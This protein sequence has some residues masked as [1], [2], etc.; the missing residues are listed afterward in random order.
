[1]RDTQEGKGRFDL[2]PWY[3]LERLAQ[4]Y[5]NGARKYAPNNWRKGIPLSRYMDSA[6][7]HLSKF[8]QGYREEDHLVA[9]IWNLFGYVWTEKQINI[10]KLPKE[11]N[12]I[13][14]HFDI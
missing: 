9:C 3:V 12:D 10:G 4:H 2:L 1:V 8:M 5:E 6:T 11:L 7:R 14:G 13:E